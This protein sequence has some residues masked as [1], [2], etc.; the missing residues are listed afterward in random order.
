MHPAAGSAAAAAPVAASLRPQ[1]LL[2]LATAVQEAAAAPSQAARKGAAQQATAQRGPTG[3]CCRRTAGTSS[4]WTWKVGASRQGLGAL[5]CVRAVPA[6]PE[7]SH[8]VLFVL[9]CCLSSLKASVSLW[10]SAVAEAAGRH[11]SEHPF[12]PRM[13]RP[14]STR[15]PPPAARLSRCPRSQQ[16]PPGGAGAKERDAGGDRLP[17]ARRRCASQHARCLGEVSS[18]P[19]RMHVCM[20]ARL[21][22]PA[23]NRLVSNSAACAHPP[24]HPPGQPT[25]R[26][27]AEHAA[28]GPAVLF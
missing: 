27:A 8:L 7:G 18:T 14:A 1:P 3:R 20:L 16:R 25:C 19:C 12:H 23:L 6:D 17:A 15:R 28:Q 24:T 22:L 11:P 4:W 26:L 5:P 21:A 2:R 13:L 10:S 9:R